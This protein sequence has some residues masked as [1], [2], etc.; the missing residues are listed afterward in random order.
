[1]LRQYPDPFDLAKAIVILPTKRALLSL[2][3]IFQTKIENNNPLMLPKII[4]LADIESENPLLLKEIDE[5]PKAIGSLKRLGL[6][7]QLVLRLPGYTPNRALKA[8]QALI[9]LIDEAE[10]T[11]IDLGNLKNLVVTDYAEHWQETLDFLKIITDYWPSILSD[12]KVIEPQ[13]LTRQSLKALSENWRTQ[14]PQHPVIIAGTTGTVPATAELIKTV[15]SLPNGQVILPGL[16][17][18]QFTVDLPL[19]H[20]QYTLSKLLDS[21]EINTDEIA[22][23]PSSSLLEKNRHQLLSA[24]MN[25]QKLA[26]DSSFCS[27]YWPQMIECDSVLEEAKIIAL[28]MRYYIETTEGTI[29]LVSPNQQLC[30]LVETELQRW[31]LVANTSSGQRLT[32]SVVGGFTVLVGELF[33]LATIG[34]LLAVLKHPLCF[35]SNQEKREQHLEN[36]RILEKNILR[37]FKF[38]IL[39]L[40]TV[41]NEK[42]PSLSGWFHEISNILSPIFSSSQN[43]SFTELLSLHK[44]VCLSLTGEASEKSPLWE[45]SD[46]KA[47]KAFFDN[48]LQ[49]SVHFPHLNPR[50]YPTFLTSLMQQ[51]DKLRNYEGIGSRITILGALEARLSH[52]D[53]MILGELNEDSWPPSLDIDPWLS[54]SM[55][56]QLGLPPLERRLGLSAH[57]FSSCFYAP[58]LILTRSQSNQGA[59]TIPSRWW[60][61]LEVTRKKNNGILHNSSPLPW[62]EWSK[63]LLPQIT[64]IAY[65]PPEPRPPID[66]RPVTFSVTE[67]E[68]LMRD[69]YGLYAKRCLKLAPLSALDLEPGNADKGQIIHQILE[70]YLK[71]Y[72]SEDDS[73]DELLKLAKPYFNK[74]PVTRTFWW[75]RFEQIA[76]WFLNELKTKPAISYLTEQKGELSLSLKNF[77]FTIKAIADRFDV[78]DQ[79]RVRV[80]DYK[81]GTPPSLKDM[82]N[83]YSPQLSLEALITDQGGFSI[84]ALPEEIAIWQLKGGEPAGK[85]IKIDVTSEFLKETEAGVLKLLSNFMDAHCPYLACPVPEKAPFFNP[86]THLE[87]NAEWQ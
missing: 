55:R 16:D 30:R 21:L 48:L 66:I 18:T 19:T 67:I 41:I 53:V 9:H 1:M 72:K 86:Y 42:L 29:S 80:I 75:H 32:N 76:A 65:R 15:L 3:D 14:P 11:D 45:Q 59:P 68:T 10:T 83:G 7:T 5:L 64:P 26:L 33:S 73:L 12:L 46:G 57:D 79:D 61:R 24:A 54:R 82:K 85:I 36:I 56:Q 37:K 28:M 44:E 34:Q 22:I 71:S 49:E 70:S 84:K 4:T 77:T 8:A 87:R 13:A 31:N 50:N 63:G 62:K 78:L 43:C 51:T 17:T 58:H 69:P 60:Q 6:F 2:H 52:S 81:T 23:L 74:N 25:N 38:E 47:I 27:E 40:Q 39:D 35:K 20:P